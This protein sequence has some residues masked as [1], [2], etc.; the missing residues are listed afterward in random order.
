MTNHCKIKSLLILCDYGTEGLASTQKMPTRRTCQSKGMITA[1]DLFLEE[2]GDL[3]EEGRA[4]QGGGEQH[5][6]RPSDMRKGLL[7]S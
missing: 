3:R 6:R 2:Q 4:F 7:S 5:M 1:L